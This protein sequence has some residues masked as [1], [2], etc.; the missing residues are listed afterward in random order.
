MSINK[1]AEAFVSD[2]SYQG[3]AGRVLRIPSSS[4]LKRNIL[5]IYGSHSSIE[6]NFGLAESFARYG[7]VANPDLPGFGGMEPLYKKGLKPTKEN[8]ADY[9][10]D[11]IRTEYGNQKVTIAGFSI[12]L[13]YTSPS[14]RDA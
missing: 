5:F 10:A 4:K 8:M 11:F 9:L 2:Y 7:N 12:C 13:L 14:P 1:R 6:R 3:L